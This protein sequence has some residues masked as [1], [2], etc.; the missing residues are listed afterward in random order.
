MFSTHTFPK[1]KQNHN[2][3]IKLEDEGNMA[4]TV[5]KIITSWPYAFE[6]EQN[7]IVIWNQEIFNKVLNTQWQ[8]A[9]FVVFDDLGDFNS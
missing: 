2:V 5:K 1:L 7:K 8:H 4:L 3:C 9:F 6:S